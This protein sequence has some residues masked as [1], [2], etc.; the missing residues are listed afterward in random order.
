M[1]EPKILSLHTWV[2][3]DVDGRGDIFWNDSF[4]KRLLVKSIS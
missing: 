3:Y 2:G 4:A 1:I